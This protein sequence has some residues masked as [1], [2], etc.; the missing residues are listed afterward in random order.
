MSDKAAII[1]E[2]QKFLARGQIDKAIAEWEKLIKESPDANTYNTVGDLY[3]KKGDKTPAI[4]SFH[5]AARFFRDEGF[6]LEGAGPLQ[7]DIEY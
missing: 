7:K 3:L 5:K 2:A 1:K 4:D 6:S